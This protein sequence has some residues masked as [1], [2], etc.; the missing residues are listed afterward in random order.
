MLKLQ[1]KTPNISC[2]EIVSTCSCPHCQKV[3]T[4]QGSL[5]RHLNKVLCPVLREEKIRTDAVNDVQDNMAQNVHDNI[6]KT[7]IVDVRDKIEALR[8]KL[9]EEIDQTIDDLLSSM[10]IDK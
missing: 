2:E 4:S 9:H 3:F 8:A 6:R 10:V 7:V 1:S 5:T